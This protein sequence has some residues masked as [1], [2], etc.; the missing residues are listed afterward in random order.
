MAFN[1][2]NFKSLGLAL[3]GARPSLFRV[4]LS[5]PTVVINKVAAEAESV[6]HVRAAQLPAATL[7]TVEVPYF[8]RKIKLA[9]DR[10]FT[11]W[12]VTI[13]NDEDFTIKNALEEWSNA[14]NTL[15]SNRLN[16][17][18]AGNIGGTV[19]TYKTDIFVDQ[20]AKD[21]PSDEQG[22][23]RSYRFVG[24]FPT[25]I[26]AINLDWDTT[27]QIETFDATF[28]YDYWVPEP[29]GTPTYPFVLNPA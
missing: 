7:G 2:D 28:A 29:S 23:I 13:M 25:S 19:G 1:I 18:A 22:I 12:T 15:V 3:G 9:G 11:D 10:T 6:F 14:I 4:R 5:F 26:G 8:G 17:A 20:Y 16:P 24:A 27:N 21:G